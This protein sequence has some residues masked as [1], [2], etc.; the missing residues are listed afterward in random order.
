MGRNIDIQLYLFVFG[1]IFEH[2][3]NGVMIYKLNKQ[4][5]MYGIA[6]DTQ[7]CLLASTFARV[8]W[9]MDTQLTKLWISVIEIAV[10]VLMHAFIVY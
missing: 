9:M 4:K 3:G 7:I 8:L 5:N 10:A 1:Y 6:V 2:V